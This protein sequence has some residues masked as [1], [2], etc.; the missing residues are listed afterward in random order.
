M[1]ASVVESKVTV[2]WAPD[3]FLFFFASLAMRAMHILFAGLD[4]SRDAR[5]NIY[6]F[7]HSQNKYLRAMHILFAGLES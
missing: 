7:H 3:G 6:I 1:T 4:L 2:R 5:I